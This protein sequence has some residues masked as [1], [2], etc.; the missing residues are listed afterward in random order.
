MKV[1]RAFL[2]APSQIP[3]FAV[4][5]SQE[6]HFIWF[7]LWFKELPV[8]ELHSNFRKIVEET[9]CAFSEEANVSPR[10]VD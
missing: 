1:N 9:R 7:F 5:H 10:A 3:R 4:S 2:I 8:D 6:T